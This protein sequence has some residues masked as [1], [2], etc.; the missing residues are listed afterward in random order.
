[1]Y[2]EMKGI[3]FPSSSRV[4]VASAAERS[5]SPP[6]RSSEARRSAGVQEKGDYKNE[7]RP[8]FFVKVKK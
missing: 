8:K 6:P 7:K 4:Q 5:A 2:L 1:M 3:E